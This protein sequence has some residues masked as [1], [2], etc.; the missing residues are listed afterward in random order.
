MYRAR[1][2]PSKLTKFGNV[3][4][5]QK[6]FASA[7][8]DHCWL[9][10]PLLNHDQREHLKLLRESGSEGLDFVEHHFASNIQFIVCNFVQFQVQ[11][12]FANYPWITWTT[13]EMRNVSR[14]HPVI[15]IDQMI[16]S[17]I[18]FIVIFIYRTDISFQVNSMWLK[19]L[20]KTR[21]M[22]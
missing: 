4:R 3:K 19:T 21:W 6:S 11:S 2:E 10:M 22:H 12:K 1:T 5:K 15:D 8:I 9:K 17:P 16:S 18:S 13:V 14:Q 7:E 20:C